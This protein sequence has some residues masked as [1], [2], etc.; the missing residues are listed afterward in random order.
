MKQR[1]NQRL[2]IATF[3]HDAIAII[4]QYG[5]NIEINHTC[6]STALNPEN[7]QHLLGAIHQDI[8]QSGAA[9]CIV[10]GPFTEIYPAAIDPMARDFARQRLT[11]GA[12]VVQ[13]IGA[14][15]MVV[16]SG[17]VPFIYFPSWQAE[18]AAAFW[19]AFMA[20]KP[21]NFRLYVENVLEDTPDM[22]RAMMR[23]IDDPR[24]RLCLDVGHAQAAVGGQ[25]PITKWIHTLGDTIGHFHLHNNFGKQDSHGAFD[26][27]AI[28]FH[29]VLA[30]IDSYCPPETTL[31][32]EA[33]DCATTTAWLEKYGY[34]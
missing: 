21:E 2:F 3:C 25:V 5:L 15:A 30:A 18:K 33:R 26:D 10:H 1:L 16:H 29:E 20:D 13:S 32:I 34:L 28:D 19:Q 7:R 14:E 27:G 8:C 23:Q 17:Y 24:I 4:A 12:Q 31:T 11:Q 9:R 22:L 6:I